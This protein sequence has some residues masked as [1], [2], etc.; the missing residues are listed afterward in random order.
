MKPQLKVAVKK[1]RIFQMAYA[2]EME[3]PIKNRRH[4]YGRKC[5]DYCSGNKG[6]I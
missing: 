2:D 6:F 3:N 5:Q 4:D 1:H